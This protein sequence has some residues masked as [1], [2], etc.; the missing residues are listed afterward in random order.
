MKINTSRG[1]SDIIR[2]SRKLNGWTRADL[3][4]RTGVNPAR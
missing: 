2:D 4:E 1:L 3:A